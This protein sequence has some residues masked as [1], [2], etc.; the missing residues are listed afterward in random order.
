MNLSNIENAAAAVN[1]SVFGV[2]DGNLVLLGPKEPGFGR[3]S[4]HRQNGTTDRTIQLIVGPV[5]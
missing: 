4:L 3:L 2:A 5:V 1:L